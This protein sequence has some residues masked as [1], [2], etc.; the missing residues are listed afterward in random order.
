MEFSFKTTLLPQKKRAVYE[1]NSF[2][3]SDDFIYVINGMQGMGI[4]T[5]KFDLRGKFIKEYRGIPVSLD[6]IVGGQAK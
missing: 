1:S 5:L 2:T 3:I 4:A 6:I